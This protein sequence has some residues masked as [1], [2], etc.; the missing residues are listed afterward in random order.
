M[1]QRSFLC[2]RV[3]VTV[4]TKWIELSQNDLRYVIRLLWIYGD[5]PDWQNRVRVAAFL[6]FAGIEV[7]HRTDAGWL[8]RKGKQTFNLNPELL[9]ELV[10]PLDFLCHSEE[11]DVRIEEAAGHKAYDF[12]LTELP[13]GLYLQL[14]NYYQGFLQTRAMDALQKIAEILYQCQ[15]ES[16]EFKEEELF[17]AFLWYGAVKMLLSRFH[18]NFL[19]KSEESADITQESM[20]EGMLAQIRLLTKGDVTKQRYILEETDT[21]MALDELDALARD[22]DEIKKKYG[23]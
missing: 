8:C 18:P 4:P 3:V 19:K 13:F 16:P 10:A 7:Y 22:A 1:T 5:T 17:G 12:E 2:D 21:W 6:H 11:M 9:P 15:G 23:N 14:E 20:R